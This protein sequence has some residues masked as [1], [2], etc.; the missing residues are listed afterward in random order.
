MEWIL[1]QCDLNKDI[2]ID[3]KA[4]LTLPSIQLPAVEYLGSMCEGKAYYRTE[5]SLQLNELLPAA[6]DN[7]RHPYKSLE[8]K[9]YDLLGIIKALFDQKIDAKI[10]VSPKAKTV[11]QEKIQYDE[12]YKGASNFDAKNGIDNGEDL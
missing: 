11:K 1:K 6:L 2:Q 10:E 5:E 7:I 8:K 3:E 9:I 4:Q 12:P